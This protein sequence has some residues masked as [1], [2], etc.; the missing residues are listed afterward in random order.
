MPSLRALSLHAALWAALC[1]ALVAQDATLLPDD[2]ACTASGHN[3]CALSMLQRRGARQQ[4]AAAGGAPGHGGV[5]GALDEWEVEGVIKEAFSKV[6][7]PG[8]YL[9]TNQKVDETWKM[10]GFVDWSGDPM[11][12][13]DSQSAN[14]GKRELGISSFCKEG[15]AD[16]W[17]DTC[18]AIAGVVEATRRL[19]Q[20]FPEGPRFA[21][22]FVVN[23]G[24]FPSWTRASVGPVD[25]AARPPAAEVRNG[26][27]I[28]G[29]AVCNIV[30]TVLTQSP[31]QQ[32]AGICS[33]VAS[34][35]A[36]SQRAPAKAM[37]M[38]VRLLWTGKH[39]PEAAAPCGYIFGRQP[40]LVPWKGVDHSWVPPTAAEHL[41]NVSL[42][43]TGSAADCEEQRG[44]PI[45]PAGLTYMWSASAIA[46]GEAA[47]GGVCDGRRVNA[48]SFPGQ[49]KEAVQQN[50][51]DQG[52]TLASMLW[53]CNQFIDP[54][55]GTCRVHYNGQACGGLPPS[56][57]EKRM[58]TYLPL[59][60]MD[61]F[62]AWADPLEEEQAY[63]L[64]NLTEAA[65]KAGNLAGLRSAGFSDWPL[66]AQAWHGA[67]PGLRARGEAALESFGSAM[68]GLA[69]F[70]VPGVNGKDLASDVPTATAALLSEACSA[71][72]ALL[73]VDNVP[74]Q[75]IK[76]LQDVGVNYTG[77]IPF[78]GLGA[79]EP[80]GN[81]T[82]EKV[83]IASLRAGMNGQYH[84]AMVQP[85]GACNHAVYLSSCDEAANE[86]KIW[87]WGYLTSVTKEMLLG[88]P[89][90]SHAGPATTGLLC[91]V[92]S[93]D[94]I[95][96]ADS[97]VVA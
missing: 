47:H 9:E 70:L 38:A 94:Q 80:L 50:G 29:Y 54:R 2:E 86:Y 20:R 76:L 82:E 32:S 91:G 49:E 55:G 41:V 4:L 22:A 31:N 79:N 26:S 14:A 10:C 18:R 39:T 63:K 36:L 23:W 59:Y 67:P 88:L 89:V 93:A 56:L 44:S 8:G 62:K 72:V 51:G 75:G 42:P 1:A 61:A 40:G 45:Q 57:C 11:K 92:I 46:E 84:T 35:G 19:V 6:R 90:K 85:H 74:L 64:L 17:D 81:T 21:N 78:Y 27:G 48:L 66:W 96:W 24:H 33:H 71:H 12:A 43:C 68:L 87:S 97:G 77:Q 95:T 58:T 52:G 69:A 60:F 73:L 53:S 30:R 5:Q 3:G 7:G 13:L 83:A 37:E 16:S 15:E 65:I 25:W 34:L 28:V